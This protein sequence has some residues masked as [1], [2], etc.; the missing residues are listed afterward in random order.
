MSPNISFSATNLTLLLLFY[1]ML[2]FIN[3]SLLY[4][5]GVVY[6]FA[7]VFSVIMK[8]YGK[9]KTTKIF[10]SINIFKTNVEICKKTL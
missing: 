2:N 5:R 4:I 8:F 10:H 6:P 7:T 3:L 9:T 1:Y